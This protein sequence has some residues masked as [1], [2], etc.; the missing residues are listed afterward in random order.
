[1]RGRENNP[2]KAVWPKQSDSNKVWRALNNIKIHGVKGTAT[3]HPNGINISL[4][5]P[6]RVAVADVGG[7]VVTDG[8]IASCTITLDNGTEKEEQE[9]RLLGLAS[10]QSFTFPANVEIL[11]VY[12]GYDDD[13]TWI[14]GWFGV[15]PYS[16]T[17]FDAT[18]N[19]AYIHEAGAFKWLE[20]GCD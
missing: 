19:Q 15:W 16:M 17:D 3:L 5:P 2:A 7:M 18:K 6:Q 13:G 1:M 11:A 12:Y 20:M 4:N 9:L 10:S 14:G 8:V